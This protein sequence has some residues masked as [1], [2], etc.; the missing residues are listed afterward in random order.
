MFIAP[1]KSSIGNSKKYSPARIQE[2]SKEA[3]EVIESQPTKFGKQNVARQYMDEFRASDAAGGIASRFI[4]DSEMPWH[5]PHLMKVLTQDLSPA[6]NQALAQVLDGMAKKIGHDIVKLPKVLNGEA[7]LTPGER[8]V[9]RTPNRTATSDI[10]KAISHI[11][12]GLPE[13]PL[14][15]GITILDRGD[16]DF[17]FEH[18]ERNFSTDD[19]LQPLANLG[20]DLLNW[21]TVKGNHRTEKPEEMI[22]ELLRDG[23]ERDGSE[24]ANARKAL[25]QFV[26]RNMVGLANKAEEQ[27]QAQS[28]LKALEQET[29]ELYTQGQ[30]KEIAATVG[31]LLKIGAATAGGLALVAVNPLVGA[32]VGVLGLVGGIYHSHSSFEDA[33]GDFRKANAHESKVEQKTYEVKTLRK[34]TSQFH[35]DNRLA[36]ETIAELVE[37]GRMN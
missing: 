28:E 34:H 8:S 11:A 25:G 30:R 37:P 36:N 9:I 21:Y 29:L 14:E 13:D 12:Q 2:L 27:K 32:A 5:G 6:P 23:I 19:Y 26:D 35:T 3:C 20:S 22:T 7:D 16:H 4:I 15:A 10:G 31:L 33:R 17:G 18:I 24:K 1:Q